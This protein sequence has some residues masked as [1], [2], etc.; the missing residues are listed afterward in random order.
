MVYEDAL[1]ILSYASPYE[2]TIETKGIK[3]LV[4]ISGQYAQPGHPLYKSSSSADLIQVS[5]HK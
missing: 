5:Q 4:Q 3:N 2:V 1:T